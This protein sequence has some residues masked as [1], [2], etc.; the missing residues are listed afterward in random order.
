M[1]EPSQYA[2]VVA[3]EGESSER[4]PILRSS[5]SA[6]RDSGAELVGRFCQHCGTRI[7]EAA[8]CPSCGRV[9]TA[10]GA[11][12]SGAGD[13]LRDSGGK[14]LTGLRVLAA[15]PIGGISRAYEELGEE[16]ALRAAAVFAASFALVCAIA[17]AI[18]FE[19]LF[20]GMLGG[21][22]QLVRGGSGFGA[23]VRD[24]VVF[25]IFPIALAAG[26]HLL[27]R[28]FGGA[29]RTN[30]SRGFGADALVGTASALPMGLAFL[31]VGLVGM[32]NA[33]IGTI[34][35]LLGFLY[36]VMMLFAGLTGLCG[37]SQR[38]APLAILVLLLASGWLTKIVFVALL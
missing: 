32:A 19:R 18:G 3:G 11:R 29:A 33:E 9:P 6:G 28:G 4:V 26:S 8:A 21:F 37:L 25:L 22:A 12:S 10:P 31:L 36:L 20:G 24:L 14:A 17:L 1:R 34:L 16:G 30:A 23:F 38:A 15:D 7:G 35:I 5:K 27:H 2:D 13:V